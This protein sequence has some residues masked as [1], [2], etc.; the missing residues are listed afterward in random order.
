MV[1]NR[2]FAEVMGRSL[3]KVQ[4][5]Y[6]SVHRSEEEDQEKFNMKREYE[7]VVGICYELSSLYYTLK[8]L[9]SRY[10]EALQPI[11]VNKIKSP[12]FDLGHL[13]KWAVDLVKEISMFKSLER[14][15]FNGLSPDVLTFVGLDC[16]AYS[17]ASRVKTNTE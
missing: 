10:G 1:K 12:N 2:R 17:K 6:I 13:T 14:Q 16:Q 5:R 8:M 9:D 7:N 3:R 15:S 11:V 4:A